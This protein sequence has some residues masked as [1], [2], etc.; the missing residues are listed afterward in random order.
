MPGF[1]KRYKFW[2]PEIQRA[3]DIGDEFTLKN[4]FSAAAKKSGRTRSANAQAA[5]NNVVTGKPLTE[6]EILL[7]KHMN[8]PDTKHVM[9]WHN[10]DIIKEASSA[11][12]KKFLNNRIIR[13]VEHRGDAS[14]AIQKLTEYLPDAG[15]DKA[16]V[17]KTIDGLSKMKFK[18]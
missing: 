1:H 4:Y 16:V 2:P 15:A 12:W 7:N 10:E 17:Q 18:K 5:K 11:I 13:G 14:Y 9:S 8:H 3:W 6:D